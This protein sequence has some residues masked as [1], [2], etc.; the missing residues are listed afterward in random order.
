MKF[1]DL[2]GKR[3]GRLIVISLVDK[4]K[5]Q[6][7]CHCDCGQEIIVLSSN[8]GHTKSCGCLRKEMPSITGRYHGLSATQHRLYNIWRG[9]KKRCYL[10]SGKDY[11]CWG[12]RGIKICEEWLYDFMSFFNWSIK[13]GY[14]DNLSIDRIDNNGHYAPSNC[15][16]ATA[17]EQANNR[18]NFHAS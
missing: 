14:A 12:G 15:R 8:L 13:N 10:E 3:F 7:K 9:M 6:W 4:T 18:R 5:R 16:W 1:I 2:A 11:P 17:K